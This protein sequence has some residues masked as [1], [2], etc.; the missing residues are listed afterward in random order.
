MQGIVEIY[1]NNYKGN[2]MRKIIFLAIMVLAG[3]LTMPAQSNGFTVELSTVNSLKERENYSEYHGL[4][5]NGGYQLNFLNRIY[6]EPQI[7]LTWLSHKSGILIGPNFKNSNLSTLGINLGAVGGI[8][9]CRAIGLFTGPDVKFDVYS[10]EHEDK[11]T[12]AWWRFGLDVFVWKLRFRGAIGVSM[13]HP[14]YED[15]RNDNYTIGIAYRF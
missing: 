7:G 5:L 15:E 2:I 14:Y 13:N 3:C 6:V 4:E 8:K 12:S 10:Q 11:V 9:I 1:S